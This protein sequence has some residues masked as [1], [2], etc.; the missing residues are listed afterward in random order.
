MK[1]SGSSV[2]DDIRKDRYM[3]RWGFDGLIGGFIF[4]RDMEIMIFKD[5]ISA[6]MIHI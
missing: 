6:D 4:L 3:F 1:A 2:L 5:V